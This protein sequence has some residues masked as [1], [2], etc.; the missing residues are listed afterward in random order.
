[1]AGRY[2]RAFTWQSGAGHAV[3]LIEALR[4][5]P[6]VV[7]DL[8]CGYGAAAEALAERGFTYVGCDV[9][10]D[11]LDDLDGR[12][13]ETLRL[14][15]QD[16]DVAAELDK[17][18]GERAVSVVLLLDVLSQVSP[19]EPVLDAVWEA[20]TQL[21]GP[22][23]V[24][25]VPNVAHSDIASKLVFGRF[26]YTDTG[27]LDERNV[28][29]FDVHRLRAATEAAGFR[30]VGAR[31]FELPLSDQR[32]PRDHPAMADATPVG[33]HLRHLRSLADP[34]AATLEFV[35]AYLPVPRASLEGSP[36][37]A[38]TA[39]EP[40][41]GRFLTVVMRTQLRRPDNLREAL[42]CLA[43]QLDDDFDVALMVHHEDPKVAEEAVAIVDELHRTFAGR[44]SVIPVLAGGRSRPLNEALDRLRAD[45]VAFLDDDDLVTA[46][47]VSSFRE[48]ADGVRIARTWTAERPIT[49]VDGDVTP[50]DIT[51]PLDLRWAVG[52]DLAQHLWQNHSPICSWAVP[53]SA[54]EA[55][56]LRFSE[57]VDVIEDWHFLIRCASLVGVR[58]LPRVTSIYHRWV[59]GESSTSLHREATWRATQHLLLDQL[60]RNPLLLPR[61]SASQLADLWERVHLDTH[62]VEV[63]STELEALRNEVDAMRRS[64][65]WRATR[66]AARAFEKV[67]P[68]V[69]RLRRRRA[70]GGDAAG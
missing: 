5:E 40:E 38:V 19:P 45:Y 6:G 67:R 25:S 62:S 33:Q 59:S 24:V 35:R 16:G 56:N 27:L 28:S 48:A 57:Q 43:G 65:W 41:P 23:L 53:R 22:P 2:Q 13:L 37:P 49:L 32:F 63:T 1:M 66:P 60:D 9:D 61:G 21:G 46:D 18:R 17:R 39:P 29:H 26:D 3:R 54:V 70:G 58:D 50:Y 15:L 36:T 14:D 68:G 7:F 12:G 31:D 69:T 10:Q 52:F 20:V 42:T 51:G 30:E 64:R 34:S 44:V 4:L 55:A 11:G 47:W 8:G